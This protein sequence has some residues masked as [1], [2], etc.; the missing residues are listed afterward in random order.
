M[1][2]PN[3][4]WDSAVQLTFLTDLP[5]PLRSSRLCSPFLIS[6]L[7]VV[8]LVFVLLFRKIF[9]QKLRWFT[10][11]SGIPRWK[12]QHFL[13]FYCVVII[14]VKIDLLLNTRYPNKNRAIFSNFLFS[15]RAKCVLQGIVH[16]ILGHKF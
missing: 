16:I 13:L 12:I 2:F 1:I 14:R 10:C 11:K 5:L 8:P 7:Q 9:C 4:F 15:Y 6:S 3:I